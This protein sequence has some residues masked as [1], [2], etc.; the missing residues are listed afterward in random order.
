MSVKDLQEVTIV[1]CYRPLKGAP[2]CAISSDSEKC[3]KSQKH[4]GYIA[5]VFFRILGPF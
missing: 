5:L 2:K 1:S 3:Q 4:Q